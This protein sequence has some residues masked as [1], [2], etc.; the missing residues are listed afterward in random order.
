MFSVAPPARETFPALCCAAVTGLNAQA[1]FSSGS[2][3]LQ[4]VPTLCQGSCNAGGGGERGSAHLEKQV[5]KGEGPF[6]SHP[7]S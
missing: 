1:Q 3:C 4:K 6:P 2:F 7:P 5:T